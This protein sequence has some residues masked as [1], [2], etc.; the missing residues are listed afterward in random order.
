VVGIVAIMV[1]SRS[2]HCIGVAGFFH[3]KFHQGIG[4]KISLTDNSSILMKQR[5]FDRRDVIGG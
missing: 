3:T 2:L 4:L 5:R 1:V